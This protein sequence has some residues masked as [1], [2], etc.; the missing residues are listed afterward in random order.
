MTVVDAFCI[1]LKGDNG[2]GNNEMIMISFDVVTLSV[3]IYVSV[4]SVLL[5][6]FP[7]SLE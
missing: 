4:L 6:T 2:N 1:L 3:L 5:P 7:L